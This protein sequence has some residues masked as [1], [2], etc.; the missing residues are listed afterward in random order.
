MIVLFILAKACCLRRLAVCEGWLFACGSLY[1]PGLSA[2]VATNG[3]ISAYIFKKFNQFL[4]NKNKIR[5]Y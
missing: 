2:G 3:Y 5:T 4:N 1:I